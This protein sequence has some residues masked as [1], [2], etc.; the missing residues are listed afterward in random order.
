LRHFF[1]DRR[2]DVEKNEEGRKQKGQLESGRSSTIQSKN[3]D[4]QSKPTPTQIAKSKNNSSPDGH[5]GRQEGLSRTDQ[6]TQDQRA[7]VK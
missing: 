6:I 3:K 7:A 5:D 4:Q 1:W 2:R